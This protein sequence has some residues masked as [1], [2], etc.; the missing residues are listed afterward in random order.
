MVAAS[1]P[2]NAEGEHRVTGRDGIVAAIILRYYMLGKTLR[3]MR[4][5][6]RRYQKEEKE[7]SGRRR[8]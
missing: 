5:M 8:R 4:E 7:Q 2:C 1:V 3:E 6:K